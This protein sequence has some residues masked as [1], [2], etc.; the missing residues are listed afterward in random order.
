MS[1]V[2]SEVQPVN[3]IPFGT[4]WFYLIGKIRSIFQ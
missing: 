1:P 4:F 2:R 3:N